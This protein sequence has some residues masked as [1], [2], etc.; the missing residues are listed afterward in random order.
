MDFRLSDIHEEVRKLARQLAE[1][2]LRKMR[3][4]LDEREEYPRAFIRKLA[5]AGLSGIYIPEVYGG[6]GMGVLALCIVTEEVARVCPGTSTAYAANALGAMPILIG[7]TE[8]QKQKY[9]S[10]IASGEFLAA[11][12]LTEAGAGSDALALKTRAVKKD[13]V[14]V[15]TGSKQFITNAADLF[16]QYLNNLII[17]HFFF[18]H[19]R[20]FYD[21]AFLLSTFDNFR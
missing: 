7:G 5:D 20:T 3:A 4:G 9:L 6:S 17:C 15:V 11:F 16:P 10:K 13:G 21:L 14:Y 19:T 8:E 2:I 12:G 1:D 18:C